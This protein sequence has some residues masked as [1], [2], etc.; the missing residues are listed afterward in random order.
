MD[1][2][3]FCRTSCPTSNEE[4]VKKTKKLMEKGNGRAFYML[5]GCYADGTMGIPQDRATA[6]EL[7]RKAGELGSAVAYFNL[8]CA[9]EYGQGVEIDTKK[10]IYYW[11]LAAMNGSVKAR[12][13]I[14]AFEGNAGNYHQAYKHLIITARAGDR[15]SL[16]S[17]KEGYVQGHVTKEEYANTLR[18]YQ[19]IQDETKSDAREKAK[20]YLT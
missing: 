15:L 9:Y 19:K 4:A 7:Y 5:A 3:P 18:S 6:N 10:A 8:G 17:V 13:N 1:L 14:G 20:A 2:C 16:D 11:E 12:N